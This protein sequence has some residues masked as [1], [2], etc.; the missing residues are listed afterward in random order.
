MDHA[1]RVHRVEG[2]LAPAPRRHLHRF[3]CIVM[4]LVIMAMVLPLTLLVGA[5]PASASHNAPTYRMKSRQVV[6]AAPYLFGQYVGVVGAGEPVSLLCYDTG[7]SVGGSHLWAF[8]QYRV[9]R[10]D[11]L[12]KRGWVPDS[13]LLTGTNGRVDGVRS[14]NCPRA[15]SHPGPQLGHRPAA[16]A[17]PPTMGFYVDRGGVYFYMTGTM[18]KTLAMAIIAAGGVASFAAC[19]EYTRLPRKFVKPL[20]YA[21]RVLPTPTLASVGAAILAVNRDA[22][23]SSKCFRTESSWFGPRGSGPLLEAPRSACRV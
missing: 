16:P 2:S 14:G 3:L 19:G 1:D 10:T 4:S 7:S 6:V 21:C 17:L 20:E 23:T 8:I 13:T 15:L 18:V 22:S 12:V 11:G 9:D 5:S